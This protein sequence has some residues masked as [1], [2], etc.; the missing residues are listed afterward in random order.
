[1]RASK[2]DRVLYC[3]EA[4]RLLREYGEVVNELTVHHQK[5]F[6]AILDGDFEAHRFDLLIHDASPSSSPNRPKLT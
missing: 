2:L 4:Q 5:Q 3:E 1:M 6:E